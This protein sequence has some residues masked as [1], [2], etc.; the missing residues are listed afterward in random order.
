MKW[1]DA[2]LR[3]YRARM[4]QGTPAHAASVATANM[5]AFTLPK[6]TLLL[7]QLR[8]LDRTSAPGVGYKHYR[9][10]LSAEVAA[11]VP[12]DPRRRPFTYAEI[13]IVRYSVRLPD[14]DGCVA[15]VKPILDILQPRSARHPSGLGII[16]ED[17]PEH[18]RL[19]VRSEKVATRAEQR[20]LVTI[21]R[22]ARTEPVIV[23]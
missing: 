19:T 21:E 1:D 15:S 4:V 10:E 13:T 2:W 5:I 17:S 14:Q 23:L 12:D 6:P 7:N 3:D 8:K 22:L 16:V 11:L 9:D 20:T 18:I